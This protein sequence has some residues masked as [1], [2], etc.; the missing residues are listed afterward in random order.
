MGSK[1]QGA[2]PWPGQDLEVRSTAGSALAAHLL[3]PCHVGERRLVQ[4]VL[5]CAGWHAHVGACV[6]R[7]FLFAL[8]VKKTIFRIICKGSSH[9]PFFVM[10]TITGPTG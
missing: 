4:L 5:V 9:I 8:A 10:R 6:G 1:R 2:A 3:R 7:L